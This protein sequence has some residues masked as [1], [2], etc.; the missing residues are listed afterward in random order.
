MYVQ[1]KATYNINTAIINDEA[2]LPILFPVDICRESR[3]EPI[4]VEL[5]TVALSDSE[6][7][8]FELPEIT[9]TSTLSCGTFTV[10]QLNE[11]GLVTQ[12]PNNDHLFTI[13]TDNDPS[14]V[15]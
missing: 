9:S 10:T 1:I 14:F 7:V 8:S 5:M 3:I 15:G 6:P 2:T 11:L 4:T 13:A 12:D